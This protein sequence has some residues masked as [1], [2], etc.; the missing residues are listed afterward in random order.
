M[1]IKKWSIIIASLIALITGS[2]LNIVNGIIELIILIM[3]F[4]WVACFI[5]KKLENFQKSEKIFW[6]NVICIIVLTIYEFTLE[7]ILFDFFLTFTMPRFNII[8]AICAF[9][10]YSV[11][12][13]II[14][15]IEYL[16]IRTPKVNKN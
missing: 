3:S 8:A 10:I 1:N 15:L 12:F 13:T 4:I 16:I 7:H 6:V 5:D 11:S 9:F 14:G 2:I